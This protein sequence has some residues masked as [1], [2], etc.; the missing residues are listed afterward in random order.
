MR[1][2][3]AIRTTRWQKIKYVLTPFFLYMIVKSVAIFCLSMCM[4]ILP[5]AAATWV[6]ENSNMLSAIINALAS[7]VGMSFVIN[8]FLIEVVITGEYDMDASVLKRV[9]AWV[10]EGWQKGKGRRYLY[11]LTM[12]LAVTSALSMNII[13][14]L[15]SIDSAK[16]DNVETIQYSVPI[17]LGM[18]LY[19]IISPIVE[20][21]IFRGLTYN[22]M[23]HY[24]N[25]GVSVVV[26]AILFGSFH[27]NL[28]QIIYGTVMG[29]LITLCYEW[30]RGFGAPVL[31]HMVA[32]IFVFLFAAVKLSDEIFAVLVSPITAV[33]LV[34]VSAVLLI[35][36]WKKKD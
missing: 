30:V 8:D 9:A 25:L 19:G 20:E 7:L 18:I 27:A 22:R 4:S 10:G 11:V 1:R 6:L 31:F 26:S 23:K 36:I 17:W 29:V 34:L 32:N 35:I 3:I 15:F 28:P 13:I 16:Y 2:K 33:V 24:F 5:G 12:L 14:T 21:V